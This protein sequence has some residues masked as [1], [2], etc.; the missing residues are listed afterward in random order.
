[1]A[2]GRGIPA[3]WAGPESGTST[4]KCGVGPVTVVDVGV[5]LAQLYECVGAS[6]SSCLPGLTFDRL[7]LIDDP[8]QHR[9]DHCAVD[10][11]EREPSVEHPAVSIPPEPQAPRRAPCT[12]I[13]HRRLLNR[14]SRTGPDPSAP[15]AAPVPPTPHHS[16]DPPTASPDPAARV[17]QRTRVRRRRDTGKI[18][19][20]GVPSRPSHAPTGPT[21]HPPPRSV[22]SIAPRSSST[23][24]TASSARA[25]GAAPARVT[26]APPPTNPWCARAARSV[27]GSSRTRLP[28]AHH[29][30]GV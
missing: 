10:V 4:T 12:R 6:P 8:I 27:R 16:T 9:L 15:C 1:M 2:S 22:S 21:P 26:P 3:M 25:T 23:A 20:R 13:V 29:E 19:E 14:A 17:A 28:Y 18:L 5:V 7:H 30:P 11:G 24:V